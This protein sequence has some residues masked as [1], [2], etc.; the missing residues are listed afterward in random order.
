M[1]KHR[2][3]PEGYM[4]VGEIAKKMGIT[5]RTLHHY[6]KA[7]LFSPS[8][9]SEG[10]YR[11]YSYK[12]MVK[13]NQILAMKH[14]GFSL[15]EIKDCLVALETPD[16]VANALTEQAAIVREKMETLAASL[17]AIEALKTEVVQ[18]QSV[19]FK[20]Y[21]D[22]VMLLQIK[23]ENYW[24][25]KYI[26]E[27]LMDYMRDNF[28]Q[29]GTPNFMESWVCLGNEAVQLSKEGVSPDSEKGQIF[30]R[31]VWNSMLEFANGDEGILTKLSESINKIEDYNK[32]NSTKNERK[33]QSKIA[34][35]FIKTAL[36]TYLE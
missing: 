15:D 33:E 25:I 5:V 36:N 7:G 31:T 28:A 26:D 29:D 19:D 3:I 18:M 14:L 30:A 27:G 11:L 4:T 12:D 32:K 21:A 10:G 22:I 6:D 23:N 8:A 13:L 20:K 16:D 24:A 9:E 17:K 34:Y 1:E 35:N 2:A